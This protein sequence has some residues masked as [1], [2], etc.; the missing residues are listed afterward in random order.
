MRL[1]GI[2]TFPK[3]TSSSNTPVVKPKANAFEEGEI[4]TALP[5]PWVSCPNP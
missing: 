1:F 3:S 2:N 4:F 5:T